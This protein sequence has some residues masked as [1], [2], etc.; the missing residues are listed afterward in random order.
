M[1]Y[2]IHD[3]SAG[4]VGEEVLTKV[5]QNYRRK[6]LKGDNIW[7]TPRNTLKT[8]PDIKQEEGDLENVIDAI[9]YKGETVYLQRWDS[10]KG[11]TTDAA[12]TGDGTYRLRTTQLSN[13]PTGALSSQIVRAMSKYNEKVDKGGAIQNIP[14]EIHTCIIGNVGVTTILEP[15]NYASKQVTG[16]FIHDASI[17]TGTNSYK[18]IANYFTDTDMSSRLSILPER[19][20]E[21]TWLVSNKS[22][23]PTEMTYNPVD[24]TILL[25][26]LGEIWEYNGESL[27]VAKGNPI[28]L[29]NRSI[30]RLIEDT[31][32]SIDEIPLIAQVFPSVSNFSGV[33]A[34]Y[35]LTG[36]ID[37]IINDPKV[38]GFAKV[39]LDALNNYKDDIRFSL[40]EF[41]PTNQV[42]PYFK[43]IIDPDRVVVDDKY[44]RYII[45]DVKLTDVGDV[46]PDWR[47]ISP[48]GAN[49]EVFVTDYLTGRFVNLDNILTGVAV[50]DREL[51]KGIL[52]NAPKLNGFTY[53]E[54]NKVRDNDTDAGFSKGATG[55][56]V[57]MQ[58]SVESDLDLEIM[59][60][61]L[62]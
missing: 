26:M 14:I 35:Q 49:R 24:D 10:P 23:L 43:N 2:S 61:L 5:D 48:E 52:T 59:I 56:V 60:L 27:K 53:N 55:F 57:A 47:K 38:A 1:P 32:L 3:S 28:S 42:D 62:I 51:D 13:A 18:V 30:E 22:Y 31:T 4:V 50:D 11:T 6:L 8:R 40:M 25:N 20:N 19:F 16:I 9:R 46:M 41:V 39:M 58:S 7:I 17:T 37:E 45:P 34:P 54:G 21:G 36:T 15:N 29:D 33:T 44:I 12:I